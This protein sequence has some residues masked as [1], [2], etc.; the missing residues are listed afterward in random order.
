MAML[1]EL[2]EINLAVGNALRQQAVATGQAGPHDGPVLHEVNHGL[3]R[4]VALWKKLYDDSRKT[5]AERHAERMCRIDAEVRSRFRATRN[6]VQRALAAVARAEADERG[7]P[8][9]AER[10]TNDLY[11]RVVDADIAQAD[12]PEAVRA[13]ILRLCQDAGITP[14]NEI[15]SEALM[16][17]RISETKAE[18]ERVIASFP[19]PEAATTPP[20]PPPP[21]EHRVYPKIGPF[22]FGPTGAIIATD[23]EP[24]D[25]A[26]PYALRPAGAK[27]ATAAAPAQAKPAPVAPAPDQDQ[28]EWADLIDHGRPLPDFTKGRKPSSDDG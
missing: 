3:R 26:K 22:T 15:W 24:P 6:F 19:P 14:R 27:T 9:Q 21:K 18:V 5:D 23:V 28:R 4:T 20:P 12:T 7:V 25:W 10:L 8:E 11:E 13:I 17:R 16:R 1:Q 2:A